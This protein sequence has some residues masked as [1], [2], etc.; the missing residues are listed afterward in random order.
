MT[1]SFFS[2]NW[3][4]MFLH[5][6]TKRRLLTDSMKK[7]RRHAGYDLLFNDFA[8]A[9]IQSDIQMIKSGH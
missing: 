7:E 3:G 6:K 2:F 4:Q 5:R 1:A 9:F 8:D